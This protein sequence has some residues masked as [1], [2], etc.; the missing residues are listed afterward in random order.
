MTQQ[1]RVGQHTPHEACCRADIE[2]CRAPATIYTA[3]SCVLHQRQALLPMRE[4]ESSLADSLAA[5]RMMQ[6][7]FT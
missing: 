1:E 7:P 4:H 5:A 3:A 6:T 2:R